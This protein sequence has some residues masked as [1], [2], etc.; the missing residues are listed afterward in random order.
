MT[1]FFRCGSNAVLVEV[2]NIHEVLSLYS[3][4]K[5]RPIPGIEQVI[6]G[7]RTILLAFDSHQTDLKRIEEQV[8]S[9]PLDAE[10]RHKGA[11]VQVPVVYDGEDLAEVSRLTGLTE[12]EVVARHTERDYLVAFGGFA[13]GWAYLTGVDP[14]LHLPRR[15]NPRPRIPAG[16]VAIAGGFTGVYPRESPGG[17]HLLG[18]ALVPMWD[19]HRDPPALFMPGATVQ[20]LDVTP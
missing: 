7:A 12:A 20:F 3:S 4:L 10:V 19:I 14:V 17:W 18:H 13:P 9:R 2:T 11:L 8:Q 6:P 15:R 5:E 16:A 1:R